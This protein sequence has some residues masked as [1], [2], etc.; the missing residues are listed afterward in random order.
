MAANQQKEQGLSVVMKKPE[1]TKDGVVWP[2]QRGRANGAA[3]RAGL[4]R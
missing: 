1:A 3:A 4:D 2:P